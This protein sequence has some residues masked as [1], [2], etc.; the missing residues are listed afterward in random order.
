MNDSIMKEKSELKTLNTEILDW[1]AK[2]LGKK[3]AQT[4]QNFR[5]STT[6]ESIKIE[7]VDAQQLRDAW[8]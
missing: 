1:I 8:L 5:A 3:T 7:G 6:P 4:Q 2:K